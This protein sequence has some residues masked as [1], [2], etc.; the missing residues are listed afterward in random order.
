MARPGTFKPGV[1]GNPKGG[2]KPTQEIIDVKKLAGEW[3]TFAI[4][5][6]QQIA[7]DEKCDERARVMAM[8]SL[9]DRAHGKPHQSITQENTHTYVGEE[10][11]IIRKYPAALPPPPS[12]ASEGNTGGD[13]APV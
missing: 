2:R 8:N 4:N 1:S 10:V 7:A 5:G 6:L 3:T 12:E 13:G 11:V 9:L